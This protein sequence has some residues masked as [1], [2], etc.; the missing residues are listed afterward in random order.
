MPVGVPTGLR[1]LLVIPPSIVI[2]AL[3]LNTLLL[4]GITPSNTLAAEYPFIDG[5]VIERFPEQNPLPAH[6]RMKL[7][8]Y[9]IRPLATFNMRARVLAMKIYYEDRESEVSPIDF[10][11]GWGPMS[12]ASVIRQ[13]T[14]EQK[15]R[16]C[17]WEARQPTVTAEQ[18][19]NNSANMHMVPANREIA[20]KLG[21]VSRY[22]IVSVRGYLIEVTAEDGWTWTSSLIRGDTGNRACEIIWVQ[23]ISVDSQESGIVS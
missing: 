6:F 17:F 14:I 21:R 23:Q 16:W 19:I 2:L 12:D 5:E 22:D 8:G 13:F 15:N 18:V 20:L 1:A 9:N 3:V 4:Q 10:V 7:D 11:M